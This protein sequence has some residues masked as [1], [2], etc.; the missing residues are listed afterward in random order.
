MKKLYII[1]STNITLFSSILK[2]AGRNPKQGKKKGGIKAHTMIKADENVPCLVRY[3]SAA[4]HDHVLLKDIVLS[5]GFFIVFDKVYVDHADPY[6][7]HQSRHIA[8]WNE[9]KGKKG[10]LMFF[11]TNNFE[12]EA[13]EI[14]AIYRKRWQ[15]EIL[16]KQMKQNFPLKYFLGDSVNAIESQIW[17]PMISI[18]AAVWKGITGF[19]KKDNK[20]TEEKQDDTNTI[21]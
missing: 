10:K 20:E 1:D 15:I 18:C 19:A 2:G 21:S 17:I 4:T 7:H 14:I 9:Q 13:E 3:S 11:L 5:E 6:I 8:Y 16:F 12:S